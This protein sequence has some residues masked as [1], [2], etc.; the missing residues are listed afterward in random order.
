M[1]IKLNSIRNCF[2]I[3]S[4]HDSKGLLT[5]SIA[6]CVY[7]T[8]SL[9]MVFISITLGV[10]L[11]VP[12]NAFLPLVVFLALCAVVLSCYKFNIKCFYILSWLS[13]VILQVFMV[14]SFFMD[15]VFT[16]SIITTQFIV[17]FSTLYTLV[18]IHN[19]R[20]EEHFRRVLHA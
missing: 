18:E 9:T 20:L 14:I 8:G 7:V 16:L 10:A 17:G 19:K 4:N 1:G 13:I 6:V 2:D 11:L 3:K 5:K 12:K 15:L